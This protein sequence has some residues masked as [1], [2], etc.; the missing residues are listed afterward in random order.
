MEGYHSTVLLK[1]TIEALEIKQGSW[2]LDC[3]L[4]DGGTSCE[5]LGLGG[6]IVGIDV[7]PE[8]LERTRE[9]FERLGVEKSKYR[10]IRGNFREL[11]NL[12]LQIPIE[13]GQTGQKDH[14]F[15]GAIFDL[16][17]S[18]LQL[19]T[20]QRGFS[21]S[22]NGPLDM[23][24]DPSLGVRAIDLVNVLLRKELYELFSKLG[25]EKLAG[26]IASALVLARPLGIKTTEDL[27][28]LVLGVYRKH[29]F[30]NSKTNPA[31]KVFQALRIAVN[32]EL[33]SLEEALTQALEVLEKNGIIVM[34][35]FH[36]LEDRIIKYT[37]KKWQDL[38]FGH[39]KSKKPISPSAL[40]LETNPRSRSSKLRVF[41]KT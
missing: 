18:S 35:S 28:D 2:Y 19:E 9:R 34:I 40:E 31:T 13:S 7:D 29:G 25:E 33:D 5:I 6:R 3:T 21:F 20:P 10:L 30:F 8:A 15:K 27:A 17:V 26:P 23:R 38:G 36:S 37:F 16:G 1:E 4:G 22:Q 11:E 32:G 12:I 24:M 41:N 39:V 14:K